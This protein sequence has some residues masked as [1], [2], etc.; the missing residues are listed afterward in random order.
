MPGVTLA[1]RKEKLEASLKCDALPLTLVALTEDGIACGS[2]SLSPK[3]L[4]H[5]HM[6]PWLSTVV[7]PPEF[8]GL[9]VASALS[10]RAVREAARLGFGALYLFT[11]S[12]ESLYR[13]LGWQTFEHAALGD[14]PIV[15]MSCPTGPSP[16]P[17]A[18]HPHN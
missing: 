1:Q 13:R 6:G 8:R 5:A 4:T 11:P 3:T 14:R 17:T 2:A 16:A 10:L 12:S 15:L 9:G 18:S 7:V